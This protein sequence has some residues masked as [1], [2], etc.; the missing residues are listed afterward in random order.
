MLRRLAKALR[1]E[2]IRTTALFVLVTAAMFALLD[3]APGDPLA[4]YVNVESLSPGEL[5]EIRHELGLD[6]PLPLR[7][8]AWLWRLAHGDL[9]TSLR[10][11]RPVAAELWATGWRT[12]LLTG[13]A[14]LL[15][16]L[17]ASVSATLSALGRR[18]VA[19]AIF[20]TVGYVLSA[21]PVFWLGEEQP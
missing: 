7:Y 13:S 17:F 21:L 20:T 8:G 4:L 9:G 19:A 6:R 16:L 1:R 2:A 10:S 14:M 12:L 18:P 3:M 11:G 5:A 15:T